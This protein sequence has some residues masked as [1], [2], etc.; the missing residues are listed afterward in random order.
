MNGL[1]EG[2]RRRG[3]SGRLMRTGFQDSRRSPRGVPRKAVE[4]RVKPRLG[5]GLATRPNRPRVK[6]AASRSKTL[7]DE[8]APRSRNVFETRYETAAALVDARIGMVRRRC[9]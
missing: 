5:E 1:G 9:E 8:R 4:M 6:F 3:G 7:H 2:G